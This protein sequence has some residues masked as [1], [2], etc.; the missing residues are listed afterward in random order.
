MD[1]KK[2]IEFWKARGSG[3]AWQ[4][5]EGAAASARRALAPRRRGCLSICRVAHLHSVG[6]HHRR[7]RAATTRRSRDGSGR[8][9][10]RFS[11]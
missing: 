6:T 3:P 2:Y 5:A 10:P 8:T 4:Q 7:I 9:L 1:T 11:G